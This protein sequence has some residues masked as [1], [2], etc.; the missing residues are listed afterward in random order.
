[1]EKVKSEQTERIKMSSGLWAQALVAHWHL[2]SLGVARYLGAS[3]LAEWPCLLQ[4][5][6][7]G[8]RGLGGEGKYE[9][10]ERKK[11]RPTRVHK[12]LCPY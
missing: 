11:V 4:E 9:K 3:M 1:M 5:I 8:R 10:E 7:H 6:S 2:Q 12:S